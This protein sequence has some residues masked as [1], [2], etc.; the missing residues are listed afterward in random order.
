ML[1]FDNELSKYCQSNKLKYTR[2]ADDLAFSGKII[3]QQELTNL[4]SEELLKV[5]LEINVNKTKLMTQSQPQFISGIIVNEKTQ[6][7]KSQR[8]A[9][10]NTMFYI[11]KFGLESHMKKTNQE[12]SNYV[13][14]L[15]GKINY[16]LTINPKD[17][18]FIEY[19]KYLY[20]SLS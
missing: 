18:E 14:H 15:I 3:K 2:Y 5:G 19:K 7:P 1:S 12:K 16:V 13:K 10:R 9:I 11:K 8:N 6:V 17:S 4:I 20:Q